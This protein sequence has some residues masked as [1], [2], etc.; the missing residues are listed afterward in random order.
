MQGSGGEPSQNMPSRP[1]V[2]LTQSW[3]CARA[4][5]LV[6]PSS[7]LPVVT[8]HS[9]DGLPAGVCCV[10]LYH[11]VDGFTRLSKALQKVLFKKTAQPFVKVPLN[12]SP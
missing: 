12:Y 9:C 3:G 2:Y 11:F 8:S 6:Y 4:L 7:V 5:A 1:S 10:C